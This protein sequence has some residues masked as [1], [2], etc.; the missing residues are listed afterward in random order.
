V[1]GKGGFFQVREV[2]E[3]NLN[4]EEKEEENPDFS[5]RNID[6]GDEDYIQAV[7]QDRKFMQKHCLRHGKDCR[8]AIKSMLDVCKKDPSMFVNTVVDIAIEAKFLAAVRHPNIIKMR[9][10]SVGDLCSS[11]SFLVLDRLYNTLTE[12]ILRWENKTNQWMHNLF[13]FHKKNE[14]AL[15]AERLMVAYDIA[16]ALSYLHDLNIIYRDLKPNNVGFDVRGDAK[17]FD[18]GLVC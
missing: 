5:L 8:Y 14:K 15:M 1:F 12:Q 18:F 9:A 6:E 7:V 4:E 10:T 3:I 2:L 17:L 13:D 11:N 16:S